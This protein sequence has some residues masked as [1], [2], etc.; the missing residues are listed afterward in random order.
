[1]RP[2]AQVYCALLRLRRLAQ[3]AASANPFTR[4]LVP[5]QAAAARRDLAAGLVAMRGYGDGH[6]LTSTAARVAALSG[7][8][9]DAR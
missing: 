1:V 5:K 3:E 7:L 6:A 9:A 4:A 2:Q 8:V